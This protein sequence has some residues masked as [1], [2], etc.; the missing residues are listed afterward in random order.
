MTFHHL[1]SSFF[2]EV[3]YNFAQPCFE[4][5][6]YQSPQK[7]YMKNSSLLT[8]VIILIASV[9]KA[10]GFDVGVKAGA[11]YNKISGLELTD[12]YVPGFHVG[13]LIEIGKNTLGF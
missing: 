10:Q 9:A 2:S 11:N 1:K 5:L 3:F 13:G 7:H 6:F 8:A 4:I 12:G